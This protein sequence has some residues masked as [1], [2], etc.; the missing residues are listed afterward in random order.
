MKK[1]KKIILIALLVLIWGWYGVVTYTYY[2]KEC[3]DK[4]NRYSFLTYNG[5]LYYF[6]IMSFVLIL[7]P[8]M[9]T[10]V[11]FYFFIENK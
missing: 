7:V 9:L 10:L 11:I 8:I 1:I 2:I 4:L 3:V 5:Q 6:L